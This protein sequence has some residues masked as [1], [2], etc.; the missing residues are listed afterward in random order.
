MLYCQKLFFWGLFESQ[1]SPVVGSPG[2]A[3]GRGG[4]GMRRHA[5]WAHLLLTSFSSGRKCC[6]QSLYLNI[7]SYTSARVIIEL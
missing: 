7:V 6:L 5:N 1:A 3:L 2:W 4:R